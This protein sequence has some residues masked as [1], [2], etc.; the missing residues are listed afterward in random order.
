ML[1]DRLYAIAELPNSRLPTSL[2]ATSDPI[3][4]E[5]ELTVK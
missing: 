1:G 4:R 2:N 5:A 3:L